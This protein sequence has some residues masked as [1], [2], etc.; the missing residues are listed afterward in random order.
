MGCPGEN[1]AESTLSTALKGRLWRRWR[2]PSP[3]QGCEDCAH[4]EATLG[5]ES[6]EHPGYEGTART[7]GDSEGQSERR[8]QVAGRG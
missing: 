4:L 8:A 5:P 7:D 6:E 2:R 3:R 1:Q